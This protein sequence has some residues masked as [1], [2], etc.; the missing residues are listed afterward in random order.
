MPAR[1]DRRAAPS[2][3]PSPPT[4]N[5]AIF[6]AKGSGARRAIGLNPPRLT[7]TFR[8]EAPPDLAERSCLL[9]GQRAN[10]TPGIDTGKKARFALVDVPDS[11]HE[12]LVHEGVA[13]LDCRVAPQ[14]GA[15][16]G[17]TGVD[18]CAE[19][20]GPEGV[21][22]GHPLVGFEQ[23]Y[24]WPVVLRGDPCVG[25]D[26]QPEPPAA[27][28]PTDGHETPASAHHQVRMENS[29]AFKPELVMFPAGIRSRDSVTDEAF[30]ESLGHKT[31]SDVNG[32]DLAARECCGKPQRVSM[33]HLSFGHALSSQVGLLMG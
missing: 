32:L 1:L 22:H 8:K 3:G 17:G 29:S 28:W 21:N 26:G 4:V 13:D 5:P 9:R 12:P 14:E 7:H 18:L 25:G 16:R 19:K 6:P 33:A 24:H 11:T 23:A 31:R 20:V 27:D 10:G 30:G 15:L 2:A